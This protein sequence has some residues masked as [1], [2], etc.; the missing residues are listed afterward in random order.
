MCE[1]RRRRILSS[2]WLTKLLT[3][4]FVGLL[5]NLVGTLHTNSL[6]LRVR[7]AVI[8]LIF[9]WARLVSTAGVIIAWAHVARNAKVVQA[10]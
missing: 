9:L 3:C 1:V 4:F 7:L 10:R 2:D 6:S 5:R 8:M